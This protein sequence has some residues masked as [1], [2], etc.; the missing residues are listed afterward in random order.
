M[1]YICD[2]PGLSTAISFQPFASSS[3]SLVCQRRRCGGCV[4]QLSSFTL[5]VTDP[6]F[7]L[8][9]GCFTAACSP[10]CQGV[11]SH[12]TRLATMSAAFGL[13]EN[14]CRNPCRLSESE[15]TS[16]S[17]CSSFVTARSSCCGNLHLSRPP[18]ANGFFIFC[19]TAPLTQN[20]CSSYT[21]DLAS[22][23]EQH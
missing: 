13:V 1:D 2:H 20:L 23:S 6:T 12:L 8:C 7:F 4:A 21:Y 3:V 14:C 16:S 11:I 15:V 17:R 5:Y 19:V 18:L 10:T 9:Y 22:Q